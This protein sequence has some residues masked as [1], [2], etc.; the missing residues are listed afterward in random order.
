MGSGAAFAARPLPRFNVSVDGKPAL[1]AFGGRRG[2]SGDGLWLS[3]KQV[4]F[5]PVITG[6]PK[7]PPYRVEADQDDPLR[8]TL[9]GAI[10]ITVEEGGRAEVSELRLTRENENARW[11]IAPEDVDRTLQTRHKPFLIV[12][13]IDGTP[14]FSTGIVTRT[15]NT[16]DNP[17]NVWQSLK[18]L[19]VIPIRGQ[20]LQPDTEDP[21]HATLMGNVVI[22]LTYDKHPWGRAEV[23]GLRLVR[24]NGK[25]WRWQ[26]D[27]ADVDRTFKSR[28]LPQSSRPAP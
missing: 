25:A 18:R 6:P 11:M 21:L 14:E 24:Q 15:G 8:A 7:F 2:D 20:K 26:V 17:D 10:V 12:V 19:N 27:P 9:K 4:R 28:T 5:E 1:K 13:T 3:L 22:E 16:L 23:S